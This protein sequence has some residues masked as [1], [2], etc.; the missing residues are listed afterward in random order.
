MFVTTIKY[1]DFDGNQCEE[2]AYFYL[3]ETELSDLP[4][5]SNANDIEN[6]RKKAVEGTSTPEDGLLM[7][8]IVKEMILRSY[9]QKSE[10]GK[11]FRKSQQIREDFESSALFPAFFMDIY[12]DPTGN[13]VTAFLNGI[14]PKSLMN[15]INAQEIMAALP[16]SK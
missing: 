16:N 13:K 12:N 9:G 3:N 6:L 2:T 5:Y 8:S 7:M 14:L 11:H 1:E 4:M 10:D 15:K